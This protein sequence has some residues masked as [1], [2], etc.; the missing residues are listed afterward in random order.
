MGAVTN[1]VCAVALAV[2]VFWGVGEYRNVAFRAGFG[3]CL[4]II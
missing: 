2:A 4:A 1:T 3:V